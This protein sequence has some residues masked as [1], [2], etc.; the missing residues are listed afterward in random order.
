MIEIEQFFSFEERAI[1]AL[2]HNKNSLFW[3]NLTLIEESFHYVN[4]GLS[5]ITSKVCQ[6]F[7]VMKT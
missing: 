1:Q 2:K 7:S 6:I 3:F 5:I 4:Y